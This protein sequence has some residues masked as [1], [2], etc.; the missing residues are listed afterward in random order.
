[1]AFTVGTRLG[2][3][4]VDLYRLRCRFQYLPQW[5]ADNDR[6]GGS[7]FSKSS[8]RSVSVGYT[9]LFTQWHDGA[10]RWVVQ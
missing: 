7:G 6:T 10:S 5:T 9:A 3:T 4:L 8:Y 2:L 1:M